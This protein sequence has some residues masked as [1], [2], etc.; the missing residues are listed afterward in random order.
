MERI[1]QILNK[2]TNATAV[3]TD[4][5]LKI[6]LSNTSKLVPENDIDYVLNVA[7][8]F[9]T[10]RQSCSTY[11]VLGAITPN[12][13]NVLFDINPDSLSALSA[14][15][16]AVPILEKDGWFGYY[17]PNLNVLC[18]FQEFIPNRTQFTLVPSGSTKN[19]DLYLTYP[20][21][22]D[23]THNL[24]NG[25]LLVVDIVSVT[26]GGKEL[27]GLV[28]PVYH[29]L[30]AGNTVRVNFGLG[31]GL[32]SVY[33]VVQTGDNQGNGSN[34]IFVIDVA[35]NSSILS[36]NIRITRMNNGQ[37][38]VYYYRLF[39]KLSD[40]N[41]YEFYK[42]G[43]SYNYFGDN[44]AQFV[45]NSDF[46]IS[47]LVDNLNR[48]LSEIYVTVLKTDTNSEFSVVKSGL[49]I[50]YIGELNSSSFISVPDIRR[51]HNVGSYGVDSS[52]ELESNVLG[53]NDLFYGDI[54]EY[55]NYDVEEIVLGEVRHRFNTV[56]RDSVGRPEGYYYKPHHLIQIREFSSF[57][58][59][60]D[61][62]TFNL[63]SYSQDLGD[64]RYLWREFLNIGYND[65]NETVLDYPF[66][67]GCHYVYSNFVMNLRRQDPFNQYNLYYKTL[68][69]DIYGQAY[70]N[71]NFV[72]NTGSNV[73]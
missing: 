61:T 65:V 43:F 58:T 72:T 17:K 55:N 67:N 3:N 1:K 31:N 38:S 44:A 41:D 36:S 66:L 4:F 28:T 11:R 40:N 50:P 5:G 2:S 60:G 13:T 70:N 35:Y 18:D 73:C 52:I 42:L 71:E 29:N 30:V 15:N 63:P 12:F 51:I 45:F 6:A 16:T 34:Y 62:S 19:W 37:E 33:N 24:V 53:S 59:Q 68:P 22:A 26:S 20:Y 56:N 57:I 39:K 7:K 25:G 69:R 48:P 10:E 32:N 27:L 8:Q 47:G 21:S 64:G 23:T 9:N 54:V 49:E 46:N 14:T